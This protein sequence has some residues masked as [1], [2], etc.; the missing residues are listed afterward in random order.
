MST[1]MLQTI[2]QCLSCQEPECHLDTVGE[3]HMH[4]TCRQG[5]PMT[6]ENAYT[7]KTNGR[8]CKQCQRERKR[9]KQ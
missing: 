8:F 2:S 1:P 3:C 9:G 5:H 7:S 6:P 4:P